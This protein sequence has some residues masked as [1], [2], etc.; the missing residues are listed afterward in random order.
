MQVVPGPL[1]VGFC[2]TS[3]QNRLNIYAQTLGVFF[4]LGLFNGSYGNTVPAADMR[5]YPWFRLNSDG[6]PDR[7]YAY[8][9]G[10]W[11]APNPVPAN[12]PCPQF[13][14]GSYASIS[15]LDGGDGPGPITSDSGAMWQVIGQT[16]DVITDYG[17]MGGR[18]PVGAS[19]DFAQGSTA[20][21]ILHVLVQA[22][23]PATISFNSAQP[24]VN[25]SGS[26]VH[27]TYLDD[28]NDPGSNPG[29]SAIPLGSG[30]GHNNMP[31]YVAG[32]WI[33]RT[34]RVFYRAF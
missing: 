25:A 19:A 34:A 10:S 22:E 1:P 26:T 6:T 11:V 4:P 30:T 12:W 32:Y 2:P 7:W 9:N 21:E 27:G 5:S 24:L 13:Y 31:S 18:M 3:E 29:M 23:L 33:A 28:P 16:T 14:N 20:G 17:S 8:A 15:T